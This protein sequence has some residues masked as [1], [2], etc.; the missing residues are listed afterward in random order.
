M[1]NLSIHWWELILR[2][3]LVYVFLIL[4]LR[5]TG[6]R[7]I[8]QMSP[9]DL[10]LLMVLSNAVQNSMNGGDNSVTSGLILAVTLV[11]ANWTVGKLTTSSRTVERLIEGDPLL[12]L[13]DGKILGEAL[14]RS[15]ITRQELIA[16]IH[17]AGYADPE[18]IRAAILEN[19]GSVSV[20]PKH[21]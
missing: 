10:V 9:F 11:V 6:K 2:G 5:A 20:I 1:W 17:K 18:E 16:E 3:L 21:H 19:D 12:L 4:L 14:G 15:Q 7:Q 13:H 8:G